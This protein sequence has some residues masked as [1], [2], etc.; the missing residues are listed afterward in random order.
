MRLNYHQF[1]CAGMLAFPLLTQGQSTPPPPQSGQW[2][3]LQLTA[4]F[5]AE[6]ACAADVNRDGYMDVLCGP[7]WYA[8]P[9]FQQ[10]HEIYPAAA[11]FKLK[12]S[13]GEE[14]IVR[15]FKGFLSMENG[16]SDN[17]LSFASDLNDDGWVDYI[18]VGHP[19]NETFW[20]ENPKGKTGHWRKHLGLDKT[21][22]ESPQ[23]VDLTGDQVPELLCMHKGT[24]GFAKP[25][26][27][28]PDQPWTWH[29][30]ARNERWQWNTHG[31]GYGDVN[32]DGRIDIL[33]AHNWWEQ[34]PSLEGKPAWKQHDAIFN[35]GGSQMFAYDVNGDGLSDVITAYEGHGYG[36]YWYETAA[37]GQ[38]G[39]VFSQLHA[40]A[41]ADIN[42]D[43]LL[44]IVTGKRF[45][46]HGPD[47]DVEPNA[48]AVLYWFELKREQGRVTYVPHLIHSDSG[49]G[50]QV[51]A[52]DVNN[53]GKLDVIVGNKKGLFVHLQQRK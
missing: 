50:T 17:F 11:Q 42:G 27:G 14:T 6:G 21:D 48:P 45:W 10:R 1:V 12:T 34:P 38:T 18:V 29:V 5:W 33:T 24:V 31:L 16:Y 19:G 51:M 35:N 44:D 4:E 43:G 20:Y 36:L 32:G 13:K 3:T 47:G 39:V 28:D 37:E 26:Q 22:N 40:V 8:G 9:T 53:D 23:F 15:G 30:A 52:V 46:A 49:V 25:Q 7:Y 41:L 2:K